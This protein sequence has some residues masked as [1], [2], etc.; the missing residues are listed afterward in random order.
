MLRLCIKTGM[1]S[2]A[3]GL[4]SD[5]FAMQSLQSDVFGMQSYAF[6]PFGDDNVTGDY[7][8][9][10]SGLQSD[11]FG[12]QSVQSDVFGMQSDAFAPFGNDNVSA[13]Q[14]DA[15]YLPAH[16]L[17]GLQSNVSQVAPIVPGLDALASTSASIVISADTPYLT[18]FFI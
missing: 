11:A 8:N 17:L 18:Y 3:V 14:D 2:N 5:A 4:Q 16:H 1:Q 10:A 12:M 6:S 9:Y 15:T 13:S 7:G